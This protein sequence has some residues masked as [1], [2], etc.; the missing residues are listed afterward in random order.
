MSDKFSTKPRA[1]S[2]PT[3]CKMKSLIQIKTFRLP[4][5]KMYYIK[6]LVYTFAPGDLEE[7][8]T[9]TTLKMLQIK[10]HMS[11]FPGFTRGKKVGDQS[12][13]VWE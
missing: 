13:G 5:L 3:A 10:I 12:V 6:K 8:K 11:S 4:I 9:K 2:P 1:T 7:Y